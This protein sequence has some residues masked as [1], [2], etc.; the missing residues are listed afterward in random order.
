M[1][2]WSTLPPSVRQVSREGGRG[3]GALISWGCVTWES[4]GQSTNG[5]SRLACSAGRIEPTQ[6]QVSERL[7]PKGEPRL[8]AL[9]EVG[10]EGSQ[11]RREVCQQM[12]VA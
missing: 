9:L 3:F 10:Q 5:R 8:L 1:S 7:L 11:E 6:A 2:C 12:A 4:V